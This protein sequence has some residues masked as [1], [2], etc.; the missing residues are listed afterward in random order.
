MNLRSYQEKIIR[1][2]LVRSRKS[3]GGKV[4]LKTCIAA[5]PSAGKTVMAMTYVKRLIEEFPEAKVLILSHGQDVLREQWKKEM[6]EFGVK[7]SLDYKNVDNVLLQLPQSLKNKK[8]GQ[9]DVLIIDEAHQYYYGAMIQNIVKKINP[10]FT[11]ALTGT[12]SKLIGKGWEDVEFVS[13]LYLY[14]QGYL[15]DLYMAQ[16]VTEVNLK[17]SDYTVNLELSVKAEKKFTEPKV[18]KDLDNLLDSMVKRISGIE[19]TKGNKVYKGLENKVKDWA[20]FKSKLPKTVIRTSGT[21]HARLVSK[22]FESKGIAHV[23]SI[24][25]EPYV[26]DYSDGIEEFK[27]DPNKKILIIINRG[28]L[29]FNMPELQCVV[30]MSGGRNVDSIYQLFA[31]VL[32]KHPKY[33]NKYFFYMC[34]RDAEEISYFYLTAAISLMDESFIKRYNGKNLDGLKLP[35]TQV[36]DKRKDRGEK[37][38]KTL[39]KTKV[40]KKVGPPTA[41]VDKAFFDEIMSIQEVFTELT[42]KRSNIYSEVR[43]TKL[44]N[45]KDKLLG[46]GPWVTEE[47][48]LDDWVKYV[49]DLVKDIENP[50]TMDWK[51]R[52]SASYTKAVKSK[53]LSE[54]VKYSNL[55][56]KRNKFNYLDIKKIASNCC[57][58]AEFRKNHKKEFNWIKGKGL[59][60]KLQEEC[61]GKIVT[62]WSCER[63]LL[64]LAKKY[65]T[66]KEFSKKQP[67]AYDAAKRNNWMDYLWEN[68]GWSKPLYKLTNKEILEK[69]KLYKDRLDIKNND[70]KLY[71]HLVVHR[72]DIFKK[73]KKPK[74]IGVCIVLINTKQMYYSINSASKQLKISASAIEK[75]LNNK[76]K[77]KKGYTF[78]YLDDFLKEK[79]YKTLEAFEKDYPNYFTKEFDT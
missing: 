65:S 73:I 76:Q 19:F 51:E 40:N 30:D 41:K 3:F 54:I 5:A 36:G 55:I 12:P 75:N 9:Y 52:C 50:S 14:N 4:P 63:S 71:R 38:S 31:R 26:G 78:Q 77:S 27:N 13:G 37:T 42:H 15:S 68:A 28:T 49:N 17:D 43:Y 7:F 61:F 16:C 20:G 8:L 57:N 60:L 72:K 56:S 29:G 32:R 66:L 69:V 59:Q 18:K 35:F 46:F 70:I 45:I 44:R 2:L 6:S 64:P 25:K 79:G 39:P 74:R 10:K 22:Y 21:N 48:N 53:L 34:N 24:S 47:W 11:V 23:L 1:G 33:E 58:Y 67:S 62:R